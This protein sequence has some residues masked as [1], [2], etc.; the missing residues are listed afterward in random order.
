M[1]RREFIRLLGSTAVWP[2][3]AHAQ[4][5]AKKYVV[6]GFLSASSPDPLNNVTTEA[7][8]EL[9]WVEGEKRR[10]RAPLRRESGRTVA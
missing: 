10:V 7:L 8:R 3:E 6:I 9:G 5:G 2:L 4:Q 1:R